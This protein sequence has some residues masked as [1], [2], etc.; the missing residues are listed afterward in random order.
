MDDSD[1]HPVI[2]M[3]VGREADGNALSRWRL[4]ERGSLVPY[5]APGFAPGLRGL[6]LLGIHRSLLAFSSQAPA[7]MKQDA[8]REF[9]GVGM[10]RNID[11]RY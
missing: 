3:D 4:R 5:V 6:P 1:N 10:S 2:L 7:N 8:G 11:R 9:D